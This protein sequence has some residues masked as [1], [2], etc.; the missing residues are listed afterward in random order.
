VS[1]PLRAGFIGL[2]S[3]GGGM[4][5]RQ[6]A[7]GVPTTVWA[8]RPEVLAD[9]PG[10]AT[11]GSPAELAAASDLV[12]ICVVDDAGVDA[13][14]GGSE[15]VLAGLRPGA[16]VAGH[17]TVHPDS[18]RRWADAGAAA[19]GTLLDAPVSGGGAVAEEGR[20]LVLVGGPA[21]ALARARPVLETYGDRVVHLGPVG[22]G[23]LAKLVNNVVFTAHL[24]LAEDAL[25][26]ADGLGVDAAALLEVVQRG[27]GASYAASVVVRQGSVQPM[28]DV[29]GPLLRK[30]VG[31]VGALAAA[32]GAPLG[33]L[34]DVADRA[35]ARMG[36]ERAR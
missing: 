8:R 28:R 26:L 7:C 22:A 6:L 31:L 10:A 27:S 16:V 9:F 32:H 13:V 30:D 2:G 35:L 17:S 5:R 18:C 21:E 33:A 20:L 19:G 14:L 4:A 11:A 34:V 3:Q 15:G 29:A 12:S 24:A 23:Q 36:Y 25:A 1:A